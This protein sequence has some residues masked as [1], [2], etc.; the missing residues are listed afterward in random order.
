MAIQ[1]SSQ[2]TINTL[3][4]IFAKHKNEMWRSIWI[5]A[6]SYWRNIAESG[7]VFYYLTAT[8]WLG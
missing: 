2:E 6:A 4:A 5:A 7:K 3:N 1:T 8:E